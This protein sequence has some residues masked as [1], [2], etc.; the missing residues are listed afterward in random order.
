MLL[1]V[2]ASPRLVP[3]LASQRQRLLVVVQRLLLLP[4]GGVDRADV[5]EGGGLA[6]LVP[7]LALKRQRLLVVAQRL[8]LLPQVGIDRADVGEGGRLARLVPHLA[9]ISG[10]ACS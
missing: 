2:V 4:Q 3:H 6:R 10:S 9:L 8:L 7:H 5:V 1:R